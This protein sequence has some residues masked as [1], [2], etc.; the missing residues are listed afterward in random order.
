MCTTDEGWRRSTEI[1][2]VPSSVAG[3]CR[4]GHVHSEQRSQTAASRGVVADGQ[5][6]AEGSR[7]S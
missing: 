3:E 7:S 2:Y 1:S 6:T 5:E 4:Q